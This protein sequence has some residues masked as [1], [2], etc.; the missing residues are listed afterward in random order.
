MRG[1]LPNCLGLLALSAVA[2]LALVRSHAGTANIHARPT[3]GLYG[4]GSG[5]KTVTRLATETQII[6]LGETST[7]QSTYAIATK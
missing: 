5:G 6:I 2:G 3:A 7:N 1:L 4:S